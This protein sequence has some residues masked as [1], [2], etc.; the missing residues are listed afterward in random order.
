M[1][2]SSHVCWIGA[3][4]GFARFVSVSHFDGVLAPGK[5]L[6]LPRLEWQERKERWWSSQCEDA[7]ASTIGSM[8]EVDL[9]DTGVRKG[10]C[11]CR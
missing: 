2:I 6:W 5:E 11:R 8:Y 1:M 9:I 7:E 4:E 3:Q 10:G